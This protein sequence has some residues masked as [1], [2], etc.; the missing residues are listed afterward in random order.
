MIKIWYFFLRLKGSK[1][2]I[3]YNLSDKFGALIVAILK[4]VNVINGP[5]YYYH[6]KEVQFVQEEFRIAANI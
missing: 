5:K 3:A 4:E 6:A 2:N 1:T